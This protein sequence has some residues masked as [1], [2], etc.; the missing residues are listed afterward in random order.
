MEQPHEGTPCEECR[1]Q[2]A[3]IHLTQISNSGTAVS[4]LCEECARKRGIAISI[5]ETLVQGKGEETPSPRDARECP[6]CR[7]SWGAFRKKGWLGCAECYGA[8]RE[9]IDTLLMQVHGTTV[10]KGKLPATAGGSIAVASVAE[11]R[12]RLREAIRDEAFEQ[13]ALLRDQIRTLEQT[14]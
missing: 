9:E 13:A 2:Y 14:C 11:L 1:E 8:F 3:T 7:M 10:H 4:H 6:A 5:D 12:T